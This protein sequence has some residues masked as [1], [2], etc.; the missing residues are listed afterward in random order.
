ME[1]LDETSR[2]VF[3]SGEIIQV[4]LNEKYQRGIDWEN[5]LTNRKFNGLDFVGKFPLSPDLSAAYGKLN[6]GTLSRDSYTMVL[7]QLED[8]GKV[9][10]VSRPQIAAVNK[11]EASILI[12]SKEAYV[13]QSSSQ[14]TSTTVT[15]ESVEFIDVGVKLKVTPT[16]SSDGFITMRIKPELSSVR[17]TL[18]TNSGSQIPIV[19]TSQSETV[20]KVK[21][22]AMLLIGGL[23]K[24]DNRD[25]SS[26]LPKISGIPL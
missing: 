12:G 17:E 6:L 14:S 16:I 26:G 11:E 2:Q 1:A 20:V 7:K 8:Y 15:S 5:I 4:T 10:V 3:I 19:E 23:I 21:D 18:T 24:R 13:T 25:D 22:G 9:D